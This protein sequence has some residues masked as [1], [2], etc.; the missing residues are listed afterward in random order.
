MFIVIIAISFYFVSLVFFGAVVRHVSHKGPY[1][2][3]VIAQFADSL[4]QIPS[5]IKT[6]IFGGDQSVQ[7]IDKILENKRFKGL[8]IYEKQEEKEY[9]LI[10]KYFLDE[11]TYKLQLID[12]YNNK[13]IH[14]WKYKKFLSKPTTSESTGGYTFEHSKLLNN[15]DVL[16]SS[17]LSPVLRINPCSEIIWSSK[18]SSHHSKELDSEN[19]I[20]VPIYLKSPRKIYGTNI[21]F[22]D[23]ISKLDINN[24]EILYKK[25]LLDILT[26][27]NL[28]NLIGNSYM[29]KDP[30]HLNDIEPILNDSKY[31]KKGDLFLSMRNISLV[32]LYRPSTNKI[33]W[34]SF[35]PWRH[36]HDVDIIGNSKIAVFNNNTNLDLKLVNENS[37]I[38]SYD[39]ETKHIDKPFEKL[40]KIHKIRTYYEGLFEKIDENNVFIEEQ[41]NGR[42]L[43]GNKKGKIIWEY[44]WD[45]KIKWSRY[46][47]NKNFERYGDLTIAINNIKNKKCD[48]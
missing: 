48:L 40:F 30:L 4:A 39:F 27:N 34:H 24:G 1:S 17:S 10:S 18:I 19:N 20:W 26:E 43:K 47:T 11:N 16:I 13:I 25:S 14:T 33:L 36:Q 41:E 35:G 32:V 12:I 37:N 7:R 21:E 45:A 2:N 44:L 38:I 23:G 29:G 28:L 42:I 3:S 46:Y 5:N 9:L 8:K 31:W 15:G 6:N 22:H